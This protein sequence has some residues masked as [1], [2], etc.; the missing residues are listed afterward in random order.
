[1]G[2]AARF[3]EMADLVRTVLWLASDSAATVTGHVLPLL[4]APD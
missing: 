3:V 1:M 4:A 2:A